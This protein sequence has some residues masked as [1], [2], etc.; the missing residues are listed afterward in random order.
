LRASISI[1]KSSLDNLSSS[2]ADLISPENDKNI[3]MT[4]TTSA[5]CSEVLRSTELF[6]EQFLSPKNSIGFV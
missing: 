1:S 6:L 5:I 3:S 2:S 4:F